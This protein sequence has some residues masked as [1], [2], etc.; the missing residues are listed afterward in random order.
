MDKEIQKIIDA[1]KINIEVAKVNG[2]PIIAEVSMNEKSKEYIANLISEYG[3][4]RYQLGLEYG[5][6]CP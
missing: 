3:N 6:G 1:I 2:K 5:A 4:T